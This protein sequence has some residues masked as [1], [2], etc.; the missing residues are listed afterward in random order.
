MFTTSCLPTEAVCDEIMAQTKR[1]TM[2]TLLMPAT[3]QWTERMK[4]SNVE[5]QVFAKDLEDLLQRLDRI[6]DKSST[7]VATGELLNQV[8][9]VFV[10]NFIINLSSSCLLEMLRH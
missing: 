3:V 10:Y 9:L 6:V 1:T 5:S 7:H 4:T 2:L 8:G